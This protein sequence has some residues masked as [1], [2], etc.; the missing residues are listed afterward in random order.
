[1]HS[2]KFFRAWKRGQ[3]KFPKFLEVDILRNVGGDWSEVGGA[4][5]IVVGGG[6]T[7]GGWWGFFALERV[8]MR[9]GRGRGRDG[10]GA[11]FTDLCKSLLYAI[12][13][14]VEVVISKLRVGDAKR[15]GRHCSFVGLPPSLICC[16][17]DLCW[18]A[19]MVFFHEFW[20]VHILGRFS[21][22]VHV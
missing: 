3:T 13:V 15:D 6:H 16:F 17:P 18:L 2:R 9:S 22:V 8:M 11:F 1:M 14:E 10:R 21:T 20:C 12:G 7:D 4:G 5:I 19:S